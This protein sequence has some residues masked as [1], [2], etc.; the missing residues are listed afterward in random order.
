VSDFIGLPPD[1]GADEAYAQTH[2]DDG[3]CEQCGD[4]GLTWQCARCDCGA[5]YEDEADDEFAADDR[6]FAV[7]LGD[8]NNEREPD[9][10]RSAL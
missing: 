8:D 2:V 3:S 10:M 7:G 1:D 4:T 9:Y 5:R 6:A